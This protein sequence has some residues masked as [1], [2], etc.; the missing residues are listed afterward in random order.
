MTRFALELM[1]SARDDLRF[2]QKFEQQLILD[3]IELQLYNEPLTPTRNRKLLRPNHLA[4]WELRVDRYRIF[5]DVDR[6][7]HL[8]SVKAIGWKEHNKLFI[9]G[10]EYVL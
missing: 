2:F 4:E 1:A 7:K 10:K 6:N 9:R 5:Y 3:A 8:V